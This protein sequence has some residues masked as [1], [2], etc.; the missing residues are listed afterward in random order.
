MTHEFLVRDTDL[1]R[2]IRWAV[3][4]VEIL[5]HWDILCSSRSSASHV[6]RVWSPV[7]SDSV[8]SVLVTDIPLLDECLELVWQLEIILVVSV[9]KHLVLVRDK[10]SMSLLDH[11]LGDRIDERV[12]V[13]CG[14]I[15]IVGLDVDILW[16][17]I[18]A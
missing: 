3:L 14:Q 13:E 16:L 7:E 18:G 4:G 17:M 8:G 9:S 1:D 12:K 2:L 10:R 6:V 11:S 5:D 15:G